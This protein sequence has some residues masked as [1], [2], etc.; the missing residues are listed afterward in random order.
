M[1]NSI[2][3]GQKS[4]PQAANPNH[5]NAQAA[6]GAAFHDATK[7]KVNKGDVQKDIN[8]F[9]DAAKKAGVDPSKLTGAAKQVVS[10]AG[11]PGH[12]KDF[13]QAVANLAKAAG[14]DNPMNPPKSTHL[15]AAAKP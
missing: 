2:P 12:G 4:L 7:G 1:S 14:V 8:A 13:A 5:S 9:L 10:D 11:E 6:L 3:I 15:P